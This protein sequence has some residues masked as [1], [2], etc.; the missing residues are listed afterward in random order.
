MVALVVTFCLLVCRTNPLG[1][2]ICA[3]WHIHPGLAVI[4]TLCSFA[5]ALWRLITVPYAVV[6]RRD[7]ESG[8]WLTMAGSVLVVVILVLPDT[9]FA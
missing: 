9:L 3:L 1:E 6:R 8:D 2:T 4:G 7:I 5:A